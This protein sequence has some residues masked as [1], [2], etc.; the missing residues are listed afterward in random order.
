[1]VHCVYNTQQLISWQC[2]CIVRRLCNMVHLS[3]TTNDIFIRMHYVA[4]SV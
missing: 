3:V 1:M 4:Y 2:N